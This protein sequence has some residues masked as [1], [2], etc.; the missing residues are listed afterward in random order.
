MQY[1]FTD[2]GTQSGFAVDGCV[3]CGEDDECVNVPYS[4][5]GNYLTFEGW[6]LPYYFCFGDHDQLPAPGS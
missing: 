3:G 6:G 5:I 2:C 4:Y 1:E